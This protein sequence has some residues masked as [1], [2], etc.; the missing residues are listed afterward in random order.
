MKKYR[1]ETILTLRRAQTSQRCHQY[2]DIWKSTSLVLDIWKFH[3]DDFDG[4]KDFWRN[5][6]WWNMKNIFW[7]REMSI[8]RFFLR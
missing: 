4:F 2:H 7:I 5:R 1:L 6:I 8:L 3:F